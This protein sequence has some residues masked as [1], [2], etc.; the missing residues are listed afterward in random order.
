MSDVTWL[1]KNG[2]RLSCDSRSYS[3]IYSE[4]A[5]KIKA[6]S[7]SKMADHDQ[8]EK[9]DKLQNKDE[10]KKVD[11]IAERDDLIK[12]KE[13]ELVEKQ[14][15]AIT[16]LSAEDKDELLESLR[17][18]LEELK[19]EKEERG[20]KNASLEFIAS[21]STYVTANNLEK[22][23]VDNSPVNKNRKLE[24]IFNP[25]YSVLK[26]IQTSNTDKSGDQLLLDMGSK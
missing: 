24:G 18:E 6:A 15:A 3:K 11:E 7:C 20:S 25:D 4:A 2:N 1:D 22:V 23:C 12:V 21:A 5:R 13:R 26:Y 17:A 14:R 8:E 9:V 16:S 19:K 10:E